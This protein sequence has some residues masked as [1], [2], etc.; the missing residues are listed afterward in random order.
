MAEFCLK[1]LQSFEPNANENN[2]ILSDYLELC[3]GCG[4]LKQVV[5]EF[6]EEIKPSDYVSEKR[7][8]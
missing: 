7:C 6:D 1:C 5:L 2:T 3:E 4:T 8:S